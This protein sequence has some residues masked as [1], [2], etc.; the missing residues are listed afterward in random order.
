MN[1][2]TKMTVNIIGAGITG[3][4]AA[5]FLLKKGHQVNVFES[6]PE[7]G[8]L[9]GFFPVEGTYLEKYY[10]HIF[11]GHTGLIDL[12]KELNMAEDVMFRRVKTGFFYENKVY[13]FATPKDLLL[14]TPLKIKDRLRLGLGSLKM[15]RIKDWQG[16]ENESALD[17]LRKHSGA[18]SCRIV[19]EPLLK[20]KFGDNYDRISAA[21]LWN[22]VV[23]RKKSKEGGGGKEAM[24]YIK[25]GYK[26][27]FDE[28]VEAIRKQGGEI[29]TGAAIEKISVENG[30]SAGII[31]NGNLIAGDVVIAT[32]PIPSFLNLV[33]SL[34][35]EYETRLSAVKYQGSTCV[36]LKLKQALSDYYWIN[37]SDPHSPFV[38]IIE[39]TNLISSDYYGNRHL[40]YLTKYSSS[41]DRIFSRSK[42]DIYRDFSAYLEKI[43]PEFRAADVEQSWVFQDR[44]SQPVFVRNY[45]KTMPDMRTPVKNLYILN[46]AHLYPESRCL[47]SSIEKARALVDDIGG[48]NDDNR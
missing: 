13:P 27:L 1:N 29:H 42:D 20:M 40:V 14:F 3:L 12:M 24:G 18:E 36:V 11:S 33:S 47:N 32:M 15:M 44:F 28:L 7:V 31:L 43:F 9:S 25:T 38:G 19:W 5:Y 2:S 17:W 30:K 10:H 26:K 34:P 37:I 21:W 6:A 41:E 22:R 45:S 39:H 23:D 46:T 35:L 4:A 16:M 8:G 48:K